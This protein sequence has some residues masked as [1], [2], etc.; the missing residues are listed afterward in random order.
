[1]AVGEVR[2]EAKEENYQRVL[3]KVRNYRNKL[4]VKVKVGK[5]KG[6]NPKSV[7]GGVKRKIVKGGD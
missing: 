7:K 4:G 5:A 2:R 6:P 1:M 3:A